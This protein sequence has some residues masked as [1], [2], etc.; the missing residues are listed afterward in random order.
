MKRLLFPGME[1]MLLLKYHYVSAKRPTW[2]G[3]SYPG[4]RFPC[5]CA[6]REI[7]STCIMLHVERMRNV[8]NSVCTFVQQMGQLHASCKWKEI[9]N[10]GC[11]HVFVRQLHL[12]CIP[13]SYLSCRELYHCARRLSVMPI[14]G[15]KLPNRKLIL[16]SKWPAMLSNIAPN[17]W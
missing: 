3:C 11:C 4:S 13:H 17:R 14:D 7:G 1:P 9:I 2:G 5:Q 16:A 10:A 12:L 15:T 6:A 8:K